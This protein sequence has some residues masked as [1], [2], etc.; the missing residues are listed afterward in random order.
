[1]FVFLYSDIDE[2]E[3]IP[4][5]CLGGKCINT[6]GSFEC[7]CGPGHR[8]DLESNECKDTDECSTQTGMCQDGRCV[9]T[10]GSFYCVCNPGF[11]PTQDRKN[12]IGNEIK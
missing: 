7:E 4:G 10:D 11:I 2:C 6:I 12:C 3:A 1:M 9:N 8:R 5:L